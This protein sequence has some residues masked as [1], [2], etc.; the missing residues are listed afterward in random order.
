VEAGNSNSSSGEEM[1][2]HILER[3]SSSPTSS[4]SSAWRRKS[5]ASSP[6]GEISTRRLAATDSTC[7]RLRRS[8]APVAKIQR[9]AAPAKLR[10]RPTAVS[11]DRLMILTPKN[12]KS[13]Q[14]YK[15]RDP[16]WIKLHRGLLNNYEFFG[17]PIASKALAPLLWLIASENE[18]GRIVTSLDALAFRLT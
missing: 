7:P 16:P 17:L 14:H 10:L 15:D 8:S 3:D 12:W 9:S 11:G 4:A 13:F 1:E 18:D 5:R 2:G 6:I